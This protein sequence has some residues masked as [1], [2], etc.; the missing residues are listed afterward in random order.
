MIK[1]K[2]SSISN[3]VICVWTVYFKF[4]GRR[5]RWSHLDFCVDGK[6]V[7]HNYGSQLSKSDESRI[8]SWFDFPVL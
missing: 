6:S 3:L 5:K 8:N 7:S 1:A 4:Y 2:Q